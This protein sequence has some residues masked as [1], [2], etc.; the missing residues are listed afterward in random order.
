[1][2]PTVVTLWYRAAELLLGA[3]LYSV[4]IDVW[5][6][7]CVI[8]ELLLGYPLL[9]GDNEMDQLD[10]IF[11]LLGSPTVR[12]WPEVLSLPLVASGKINLRR[13]QDLYMFN[14]LNVVFPKLAD[15]GH[16]LFQRMLA[17]DPAKRISARSALRHD[18][19]Y[20]SPYP[21]EQDLMPTYPT[22][23]GDQ[24]ASVAD[25]RSN[26]QLYENVVKDS[27]KKMRLT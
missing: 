6:A 24:V 9:D 26:D 1:M 14:N 22:N 7:G 5:A 13:Q 15:A 17:Y 19:F 25:K 20:T 4:E 8:G 11:K 3:K 27:S 12:I 18:Y 21:K 23:H 16:D 10:K 2:T